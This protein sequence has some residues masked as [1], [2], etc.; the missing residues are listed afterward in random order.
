[1][2]LAQLAFALPLIAMPTGDAMPAP[3]KGDP[4]SIPPVLANALML[5]APLPLFTTQITPLESIRNV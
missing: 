5:L 4:V 2:Q 3:V 1:L